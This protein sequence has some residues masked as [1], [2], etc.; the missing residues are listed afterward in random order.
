M[1]TGLNIGIQIQ[2][3]FDQQKDKRLYKVKIPK[4]SLAVEHTKK[5]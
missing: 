5:Y 2:K 3:I 1:G 4:T